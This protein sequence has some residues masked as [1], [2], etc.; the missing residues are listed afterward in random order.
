MR[1]RG[2]LSRQQMME[3]IIVYSYYGCP[4]GDGPDS[5]IYERHTYVDLAED[6]DP[7]EGL[8]PPSGHRGARHAGERS[9]A[10][11]LAELSADACRDRAPAQ[12]CR[13]FAH[14]ISETIR[15]RRRSNRSP[16][17]D[18]DRGD[19]CWRSETRCTGRR[20]CDGSKGRGFSSPPNSPDTSATS[21]S[22]RRD[23]AT[24]PAPETNA[25][26][27]H[28]CL[29]LC[30]FVE[31]PRFRGAVRTEARP[32]DPAR[33]GDEPHAGRVHPHHHPHPLR[34]RSVRR[35]DRSMTLSSARA[36]T[37]RSGAVRRRP[38]HAAPVRRAP[39]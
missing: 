33:P 28:S 3:D 37:A 5:G 14:G 22:G 12:V 24:T 15:P 16:L 8:D 38:R 2:V 23:Y 6:E 34:P 9:G 13:T 21:A 17:T 32:A 27:G 31:S 10:G 35:R 39:R 36:V 20:V 7:P 30:V 25:W 18:D 29:R 19:E 11:R 26:R 1:L 4:P